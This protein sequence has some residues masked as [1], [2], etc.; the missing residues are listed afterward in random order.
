MTT[1]VRAK[2]MVDALDNEGYAGESYFDEAINASISTVKKV[3]YTL[4]TTGAGIG[5]FLQF[6]VAGFAWKSDVGVRLKFTNLPPA[7]AAEVGWGAV[8]SG[9]PTGDVS[10]AK[11]GLVVLDDP[12]LKAELGLLTVFNKGAGTVHLTLWG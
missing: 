12:I 7:V 3:E 1:T 5:I 4:A 6:D 9:A 8:V 2:A 11:M 10:F